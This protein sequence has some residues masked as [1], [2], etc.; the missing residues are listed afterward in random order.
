MARVVGNVHSLAI[1]IFKDILQYHDIFSSG[2]LAVC[3]I[4][5]C[6]KMMSLL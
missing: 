6:F 2:V 5:I 3:N 1:Y 4:G